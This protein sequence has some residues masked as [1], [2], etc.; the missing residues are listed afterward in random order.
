MWLGQVIVGH[1]ACYIITFDEE[2]R[3]RSEKKADTAFGA[4]L[5]AA[6]N[7]YANSLKEQITT[8][9]PFSPIPRMDDGTCALLQAGRERQGAT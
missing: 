8:V 4:D 5:V 1:S 9:L 7:W 6:S 3:R 2:A